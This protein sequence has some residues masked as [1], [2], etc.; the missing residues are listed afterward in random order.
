MVQVFDRNIE[1]IV[2]THKDRLA[3]FGFEFI[4]RVCEHFG[5][6]I[7]VLNRKETSPESELVQDILAIIHVFSSRLYGLRKYKKELKGL[8]N[9]TEQGPGKKTAVLEHGMQEDI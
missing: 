3:R 2:V 7:V 6:R 4:E 8:Q 5:T 9:D 1:E